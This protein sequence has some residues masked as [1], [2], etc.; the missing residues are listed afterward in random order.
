MSVKSLN[1]YEP[2][3]E[4]EFMNDQLI[5]DESILAVDRS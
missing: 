3:E 4:E 1:G 2:S 5:F